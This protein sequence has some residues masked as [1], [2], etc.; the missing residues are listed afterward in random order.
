MIITRTPLRISFCGGGT[1]I[2]SFYEQAGYGAVCSLAINKYVYVMCKPLGSTFQGNYSL[3]Y[4]QS[5]L[6]W[7]PSKIKHPI[8]REALL[9]SELQDLDMATM[10]DIPSGTGMGSS[11]AFCVGLTNALSLLKREPLL[12]KQDLAA[13]AA[14]LEIDKLKEPIGKQDHYSAAFG[15]LNFIRF[16]AG[17]QVEVRPLILDGKKEAWFMSHLLLLSTGHQDRSASQIL[18]KPFADTEALKIMRGQAQD[19]VDVFASGSPSD[20]GS[21]I[22]EGWELKKSLSD[23]IS[24]PSVDTTI[25]ACRDLGAYGCKLLGA[26]GCGYILVCAKPETHDTIVRVCGLKAFGFRPDYLGCISYY[27]GEGS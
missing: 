6:E 3:K 2:A 4:S 13:R 9:D 17:G 11:S 25:R 18:S 24:T 16:E 19:C 8:I 12:S 1:D 10:S 15:G 5:E 26:G 21:L 23:Q 7:H 14:T 27:L 20:L 22:Q